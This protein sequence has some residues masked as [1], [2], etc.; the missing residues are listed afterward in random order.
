VRRR[1]R[2]E[3][4]SA[5]IELVGVLPLLLL[6]TLFLWQL[7]VT[8]SAANKAENAA[9]TAARARSLGGDATRAARYALPPGQRASARVTVS[10]DRVEVATETPVVMSDRTF[11]YRVHGSAEIPG[12]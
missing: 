11:S 1:G 3:R 12:D 7:D 5:S 8:I 6:V 10:G 4:G 2:S 9:R